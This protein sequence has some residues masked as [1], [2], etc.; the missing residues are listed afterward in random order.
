MRVQEH[1]GARAPSFLLT[2]DLGARG[3]AEAVL[4]T[5]DYDPAELE[6]TQV[7]CRLEA[8]GP[9][10]AGAHSHG[11]GFVLVRPDGEVEPGTLV[12]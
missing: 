5:G 4:S 1:A 3:E 12:T 11:K 9:V 8:D 2:L 10:V 6:G 7:V